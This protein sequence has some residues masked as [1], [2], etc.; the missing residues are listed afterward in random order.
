MPLSREWIP[1]GLLSPIPSSP[2]IRTVHKNLND[3]F[4]DSA[5][6]ITMLCSQIL[7]L[8]WWCHSVTFVGLPT[9]PRWADQFIK[10]FYMIRKNVIPYRFQPLEVS[11][12]LLTGVP[13]YTRGIFSR[14]LPTDIGAADMGKP[15]SAVPI[16]PL[17]FN[18]LKEKETKMLLLYRLL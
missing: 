2:R 17:T 8:V 1:I 9:S 4:P 13:P 12:I 18:M 5:E 15:V 6:A 11:N 16:H 3:W 7:L 14:Y 10:C